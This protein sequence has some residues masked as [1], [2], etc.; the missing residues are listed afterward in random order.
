MT[1]IGD[2]FQLT[3]DEWLTWNQIYHLM[4]AAAGVEPIL[5]HIAS[6]TIAAFDSEPGASLL[7]DRANSVIFDNTKVKSLVPDYV[8]AIPFATGA[9][10]IVDW[11]NAEPSRHVID[12]GLN[13]T[14]DKLVSAFGTP[15]A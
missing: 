5:L 8:A 2:S 4:G 13:A 11:Y 10:Q 9:R 15:S 7:G 12:A 6:E 3:S 1:A 14:F